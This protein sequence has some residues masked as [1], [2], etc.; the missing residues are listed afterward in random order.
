MQQKL[1]SIIFF[2]LFLIVSYAC[3][4]QPIPTPE[5]SLTQT[6]V[7]AQVINT[8]PVAADGCGYLIR[9]AD[10]Q[11]L[12]A[13]NLDAVFMQNKLKVSLTY[14]T[15]SKKFSCGLT[16]TEFPTIEIVSIAKTQ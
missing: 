2:T 16:G 1:P 11:D 3:T 5:D 4:K 15:S 6:S 10:N 7:T 9:T 13:V 8:G 12:K 14:T